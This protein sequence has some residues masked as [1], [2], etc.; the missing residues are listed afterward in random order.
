VGPRGAGRRRFLVWIEQPALRG[1]YLRIDPLYAEKIVVAYC[2]L[3]NLTLDEPDEGT[4][5][6]DNRES[7]EAADSEG[8]D[9]RH[10]NETRRNKIILNYFT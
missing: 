6:D 7:L 3:H 5:P 8:R 1:E 9:A 10:E 4:V 2:I